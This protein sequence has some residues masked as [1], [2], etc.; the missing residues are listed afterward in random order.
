MPI[1]FER[2]TPL[3]FAIGLVSGM[4][5]A[6]L[7]IIS[8]TRQ[9]F[10]FWPPPLLT[11]WQYRLFWWLFR[12]LFSSIVILSATE[13]NKDGF[14]LAS[15]RLFWGVPVAVLGL[16]LAMY[17]SLYLGW[18]N[19][20][21]KKKGLITHGIY[22]WS[23]NPIYIVSVLGFIGWAVAVNALF[24]YLLTTPLIIFYIVAPYLEEPWLEEQYAEEY[25]AYKQKVP[26]F[27]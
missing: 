8:Y 9:N 6:V 23:R 16:S 21:G 18:G 7:S 13:F 14:P 27:F 3:I 26:R 5:L 10:Q 2:M 4:C 11:C 22:A 1:E 20:H 19:A 12:I 17:F 24:V 25:R 15:Q